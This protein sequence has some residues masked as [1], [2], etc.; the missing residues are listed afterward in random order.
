MASTYEK[1]SQ[2][3]NQGRMI[4]TYE[5]T[6]EH[7]RLGLAFPI[8]FNIIM[9]LKEL[10]QYIFYDHQQVLV[11]FPDSTWGERLDLFLCRNRSFS[12]AGRDDTRSDGANPRNTE[13]G[14]GPSSQMSERD[15]RKQAQVRILGGPNSF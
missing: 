3:A 1:A 10:S 9:L 5:V 13:G 7:T 12:R 11:K 8:P 2:Q 14:T 6:E 15:L 4:Y